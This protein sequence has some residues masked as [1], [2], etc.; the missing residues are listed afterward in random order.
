MEHC[1]GGSKTMDKTPLESKKFIFGITLAGAIIGSGALAVS[2]GMAIP[3]VLP[4]VIDGLKWLAGIYIG[5]QGSSDV[6]SI[7]KKTDTPK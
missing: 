2:G 6:V 5:V 3:A 4:L 1:R 7:L